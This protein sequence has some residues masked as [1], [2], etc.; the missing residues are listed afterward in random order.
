M[1]LHSDVSLPSL[2]LRVTSRLCFPL[3]S[4]EGGVR[5][6]V[7]HQS[8]LPPDD[9]TNGPRS[10]KCRSSARLSRIETRAAFNDPTTRLLI[11]PHTEDPM[12]Q[13]I[14]IAAMAGALAAAVTWLARGIQFASARVTCPSSGKRGRGR[15]GGGSCGKGVARRRREAHSSIPIL[16]LHE[17]ARPQITRRGERAGWKRSKNNNDQRDSRS[18]ARI[19]EKKAIAI[20]AG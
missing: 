19:S 17:E 1:A 11:A 6:A 9:I 5:A 10:R 18:S 20:S 13:I 4:G 2:A 14:L 15:R 7:G 8:F 16:R 3:P 12:T